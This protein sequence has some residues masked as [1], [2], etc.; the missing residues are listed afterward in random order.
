MQIALA[1]LN[2]HIGNFEYNTTNIINS[3]NLAKDKGANLIV[4]SELSVC[5]Y[6]PADMLELDY[7]VDKCMS[8]IEKIAKNCIG[9]TAIVGAPVKNQKA[10]GK[11][12]FNSAFVL[13][14]GGIADVYNKGLL[15]DYD[16]FDEYRY[17]EPASSFKTVEIE[18]KTI[19]LTICED[20]WNM[21]GSVLYSHSPMEHLSAYKPEMIINI[22]ASPFAYNHAIERKKTMCANSKHYGIPLINV[23]QVGAQTDL[24]F[25]GGSLAINSR[26]EVV[27]ELNFFEE[28]FKIIRFEDIDNIKP[29]AFTDKQTTKERISLIHD[30]LI[31]GIK[32]F[33]NK[34][35]FK[36]AIL[37]LS[38]GI[39]SAVTL[40]LTAKAIGSENLWAVLMPGPYSSEHSV[41]DA[42]ELANNMNIQ[43]DIISIN[44][45]VSAYQKT[46]NP[47]FEGSK[48]GI[49]EENIQARARA[50]I[51][52]ALSN[53]FGHILL[54]TS[55]K[56]EAAVGYGTLYGDMC[57]GLSVL[58]DVYKTDVFELARFI[59]KDREIIPE[60]TITKPPSAEL[61]PDQKDSDS[62]PEYD[63]L[64]RILFQYIEEK[65]GLEEIAK[66]NI[67]KDII[68]KVLGM[69]NSNEYKRY[70]TAPVLRVSDKAFGIGRRM[71]I[72]A[73]YLI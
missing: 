45:T 12:L 2:F 16:V 27:S 4:F 13:Q 53:K 50:V 42:V 73:K 23:N 51:L 67:D 21:N 44:E 25:D 49:A 35:G 58:G 38:G 20:L 24:L 48:P 28:D 41:N 9:I 29:I 31:M 26:G 47:K 34:M 64:D 54:N 22:S 36:K 17:F 69:V 10:K 46:L 63:L 1:Q 68:R 57:G 7:F 39:D 33:F 15:P 72:V 59:N 19:A 71:P 32:D 3:I 14:N 52:M 18:G 62:L 40:A 66:D 56:S 11:R 65:K 37:G 30:A 8:E 70:Q 6:S 43:Y 55:N 61:K 60:N 5:G